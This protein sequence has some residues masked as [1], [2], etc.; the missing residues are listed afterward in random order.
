MGTKRRTRSQPI[1]SQTAHHEKAP[2]LVQA[3]TMEGQVNESTALKN[4][5]MA[6]ASDMP[7]GLMYR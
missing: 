3:W 1:R 2:C 5:V 7:M 4:Q 6:V